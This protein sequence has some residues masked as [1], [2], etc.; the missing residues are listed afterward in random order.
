[1]KLMKT[2]ATG[3]AA[4]ALSTAFATVATPVMAQ[5]TTSDI[6]GVVTDSPGPLCPARP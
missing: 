5:Q 2:L 3:V 4:I 6:R 1:M